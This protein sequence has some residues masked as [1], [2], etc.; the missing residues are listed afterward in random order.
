MVAGEGKFL[1]RGVRHSG[2]SA[3]FV[4]TGVEGEAC[5]ED[6]VGSTEEEWTGSGKGF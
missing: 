2:A 4:G 3:R 5:K 6:L 1:T